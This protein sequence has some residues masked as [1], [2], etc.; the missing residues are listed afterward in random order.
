VAGWPAELLAAAAAAAAGEICQ[1][2]PRSGRFVRARLEL[3]LACRV[4]VEF[5]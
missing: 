4:W 2:N 1:R 5:E 3:V